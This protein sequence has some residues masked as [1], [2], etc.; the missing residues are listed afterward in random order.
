MCPPTLLNGFEKQ[1]HVNLQFALDFLRFWLLFHSRVF[2]P[3]S[4]DI[5]LIDSC[6][7]HG[8]TS[9]LMYNLTYLCLGECIEREI[10]QAFVV[11]LLLLSTD[12]EQWYWIKAKLKNREIIAGSCF[13]NCGKSAKRCSSAFF[14]LCRSLLDDL[15]SKSEREKERL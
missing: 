11:I 13:I 10:F 1:A 12:N 4:H 8:T 2:R 7:F 5:R 6:P 14:T 9:L 15:E 3:A